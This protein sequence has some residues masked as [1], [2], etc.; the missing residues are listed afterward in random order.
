MLRL[1]RRGEGPEEHTHTYTQ[2]TTRVNDSIFAKI[3]RPTAAAR[4]VNASRPDIFFSPT[5]A[6]NSNPPLAPAA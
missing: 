2:D 1:G 6:G 3:R 5:P 4:I